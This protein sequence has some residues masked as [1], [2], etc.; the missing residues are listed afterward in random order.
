MQ[1]SHNL[2]AIN[3]CKFFVI[4]VLGDGRELFFRC[5]Q[6]FGSSSVLVQKM[7]VAVKQ[8]MKTEMSALISQD[9]TTTHF[10]CPKPFCILVSLYI[11][12]NS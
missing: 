10:T 5:I 7:Q 2:E 4:V 12:L 11:F 3:L 9:K 8:K 1:V 6:T